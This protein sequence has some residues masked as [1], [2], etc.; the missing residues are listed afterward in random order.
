MKQL[1]EVMEQPQLGK[2]RGD[3]VEASTHA[4]TSN[5]GQ[6]LARWAEGSHASISLGR[7]WAM[8]SDSP[9]KAGM[10]VGSL[11]YPTSLI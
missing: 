1:Q 7:R 3:I 9:N 5:R 8:W 6:F 2:L 11:R 10:G 4:E